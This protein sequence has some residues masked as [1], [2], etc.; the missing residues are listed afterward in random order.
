M[1][2]NAVLA[3]VKVAGRNHDH[4]TVGFGEIAGFSI[5]AS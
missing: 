3:L 2:D 4:L 5:S 1:G